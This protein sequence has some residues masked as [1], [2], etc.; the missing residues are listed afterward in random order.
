[1]DSDELNK[2]LY[3][4]SMQA[5]E[6]DYECWPESGKL[7]PYIGWFWRRVDWDRQTCNLGVIPPNADGNNEA[8]VGFME[9]NKWDYP[10][11]H[12]EGDEWEKLRQKVEVLVINPTQAGCDELREFMNS[13]APEWAKQE[14]IDFEDEWA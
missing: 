6:N 13:L 7:V 14:Q 9:N 2:R 11:F 1:M 5:K 10:S 8:L 12:V 4:I 3:A